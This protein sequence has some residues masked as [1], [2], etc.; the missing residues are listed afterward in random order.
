MAKPYPV[1]FV[2]GPVSDSALKPFPIVA[3]GGVPGGG[4]DPVTW[5]TLDGKPS[6]FPPVVGTGATQAAAGNHTHTAAAIGAAPTS[7]THTIANV[8]GLQAALDALS[9]RIDA[10]EE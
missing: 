7:H 8:T 5:S 4:G 6:T 10:L 1:E 3:V 9:D 2:E